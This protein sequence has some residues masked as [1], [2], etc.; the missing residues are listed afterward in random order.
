MRQPL[1]DSFVSSETG[2]CQRSSA[3][4]VSFGVTKFSRSRH[5]RDGFI[6]MRITGLQQTGGTGAGF[7]LEQNTHPAIAGPY[8]SASPALSILVSEAHLAPPRR[9]S[10]PSIDIVS[11]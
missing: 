10:A 2:N 6:A 11:N 1:V 7:R 8:T 9:N 5:L 4:A 3:S